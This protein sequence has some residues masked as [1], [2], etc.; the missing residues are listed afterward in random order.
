MTEAQKSSTVIVTGDVTIDW[1]LARVQSGAPSSSAWS[2]DDSTRACAQVGGAALL[3]SLVDAV[4]TRL[5][6]A[7]GV[8]ASVSRIDVAAASLT[9]NASGVHH[10][11]AMWA[12][13]GKKGAEVWRVREFLGLDR[14]RPVSDTCASK[15]LVRAEES[16][17]PDLVILDDANLG[18]RGD[19]A[20]W[21]TAVTGGTPRWVILKS[22]RPVAAGALWEHLLR[23]HADRLIVVM[24]LNDLRRTA[25]QVSR[26]LSWERTAQD[27]L[28]ELTHNPLV[29]GLARCT[30]TVVSLGTEGAILISP[31]ANPNGRASLLYDPKVMEG[32]WN[33]GSAGGMIGYTATLTAAIAR[34]VLLA[35]E[36][37]DLIAGIQSGV[38]AMR[39]LYVGGYQA[40]G[41]ATGAPDLV[42][43]VEPIAQVIEQMQAPLAVATIRDPVASLRDPTPAAPQRVAPDMWTILEDRYQETLD[44]VAEEI[45][46][47]GLD[48]A[49][50]GV[51]VGQFG[52]LKT[53]DRREIEA[54]TS[55]AGLMVE[56]CQ[57]KQKRPLSVAVFGPPGSG[58]SFGVKQ[59]AES[60]RPGEIETLTFNLSQFGRPE[61]LLGAFHQVRDVA[62]AGKIP[63]VFWDEFDTTLSSEK[64]GWLRYFLAPMQDGSFQEGQITHPIGRC[65][66]VFAGGTCNEMSAFGSDLSE[67][68]YKAAKVRDFVSRLKG[69]LNV[70][71]PNR[72]GAGPGDDPYYVIRRAIFLRGIFERS[73]PNLFR[74]QNG[75]KAL[76]ID[77][78]VLRAFLG[79]R[80]FKHGVRSMESLVAMSPLSGKTSF[81][82]S[83]LP[84]EPQLEVHVDAQD[85]SARVQEITLTPELLERLAKAA[86]N[87]WWKGKKAAERSC[88][89]TKSEEKKTHPW[90][91]EY[92]ALPEQAKEANRTNVQTIPKKLAAAGY[93]MT[94]ARS[95]EPALQFPGNDLEKLAEYEH[96]LW[97]E[98]R[99]AAG[100]KLGVPSEADPKRNEY[101][102]PWDEV[103]EGIKQADRDLIQ[104]IPVILAE[105]GYAIVKLRSGK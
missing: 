52:E 22:A 103:P 46:R 77:S 94:P 96:E 3:G 27:L 62:L 99:L 85:F 5:G 9:P 79:T 57:T 33:D 70:L 73:T 42:F 65:I 95:N 89:P 54:F 105:A 21:P 76:S 80:E 2:A 82:R 4:T 56:Y 93:V 58:K 40:I 47:A 17:V 81:E 26:R 1:N 23:A 50:H 45:V 13:F 59:V 8:Q 18:F 11:Y 12:R 83:S 10:S 41:G 15:A 90:M 64:L 88:G 69:F 101:I 7:K 66:F 75:V 84:A 28:W 63:L 102:V 35:P 72:Q 34:Q 32:G 6:A 60:V 25:V 38:A 44:R 55:I 68:E 87:V 51:P 71:G 24:T 100:Y 78:G 19:E 39:G 74:L 43:P 30:H 67:V 97:M 98:A 91:V 53:V 29:N 14:C 16:T 20:R 48:A 92:E 104:G 31:G 61:E 86:H 37:P 49:L 36:A